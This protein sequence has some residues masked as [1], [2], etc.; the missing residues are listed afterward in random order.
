M[1]YSVRGCFVIKTDWD[2]FDVTPKKLEQKSNDWGVGS[3]KSQSVFDIMLYFWQNSLA[4]IFIE[5]SI[6]LSQKRLMWLGISL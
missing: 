1:L 4:T 6:R 5:L 2:K 3:I